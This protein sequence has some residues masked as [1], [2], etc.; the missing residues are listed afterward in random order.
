MSDI[1]P[2]GLS[3]SSEAGLLSHQIAEH[4]R[5]FIMTGELSG[6]TRIR[7]R[8]LSEKL[9]VSRTPLREALKILAADEMVVLLPNRGA[10]VAQPTKE[11]LKEKLDLLAL[12][13]GFAGSLAAENATDE[14]IAETR[15][16]HFEMAAAF[17]R[18]DRQNY[19]IL[20]QKIHQTIV[21]ASHNRA[22][23]AMYGQLNRQLYSY[24][25]R[26][27]SSDET[28]DTAMR[29][30]ERIISLLSARNAEELGSFMRT[31]ACSTW[32]VL[33]Q[34]PDFEKSSSSQ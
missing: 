13:E 30:H 32:Q 27:S 26:G 33:S 1:V 29:E 6:G 16:L 21:S 20:N 7:E 23:I 17:E 19:F 25:Y 22:L 3:S 8:T 34:H 24:R 9:G 12:L 5:H 28:W 15:A 11:E 10:I 18:K 2:L 4:L 31:H 14:E